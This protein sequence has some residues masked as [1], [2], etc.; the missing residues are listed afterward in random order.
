MNL[1]IIDED[2]GYIKKKIGSKFPELTIHAAADES[3][4]GDFVERADVLLAKRTSDEII[5]R[6]KKLEWIQSMITGVD[7]YLNLPSLRKET[8]LTSTRG[9]HG[10]QMSELAI[11]LMLSLNRKFPENIRNQDRKIWERW[12][13]ILLWK[14]KVGILGVG[15]IGE[16][17]SE[18]CKAFGMTVYGIDRIKREIESVDYFYGP[19]ELLTVL[20]KVDYFINVVPFT[21]ETEKMIG[22]KEF[23]AMKPTAFFISVGRGDTV[24]ENALIEALESGK[25]AGAAL[26]VFSIEPLPKES[27]LWE[28]KNV[29]ITPHIGGMSDIYA[30]QILPIFEENLRR[31]LQGERHNLINVIEWYIK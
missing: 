17:I 27:L 13:G 15:V 12:P 16:A 10:P 7:Y 19:E 3:E 24:D 18:K 26:D 22:A 25:F 31:F 21:P 30:D 23:S 4:V 5:K 20:E 11:L 28:M 8:L 14:K 1:L 29:I 9:I 2:A 6:A